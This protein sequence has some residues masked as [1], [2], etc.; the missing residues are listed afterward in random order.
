MGKL[1]TKYT[2][3]SDMYQVIGSG[4]DILMSGTQ[5]E[6]DDFVNSFGPIDESPYSM[7][8]VVAPNETVRH[9]LITPDARPR[10]QYKDGELGDIFSGN[11]NA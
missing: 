2:N 11:Y 6:C 3:T 4:T 1:T 5:N 10:T 9:N 7:I 8:E